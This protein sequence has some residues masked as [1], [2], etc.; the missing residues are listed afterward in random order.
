MV[1]E[2]ISKIL[3]LLQ[4]IREQFS[5]AESEERERTRVFSLVNKLTEPI[6]ILNE[7][8]EEAAQKKED[9][10]ATQNALI[11]YYQF[12]SSQVKNEN[13]INPFLR[14]K[15][16]REIFETL[17]SK[18]N[19][20]ITRLSSSIGI[21][22]IEFDISQVIEPQDPN[23]SSQVMNMGMMMMNLENS[24][25]NWQSPSHTFYISNQENLIPDLARID[26]NAESYTFDILRE[27]FGLDKQSAKIL[28]DT[29]DIERKGS[30]TPQEFKERRKII[31]KGSVPDKASF[32]F[33]SWDLDKNGFLDID[34]V[35][36]ALE[37]AY[38]LITKFYFI[39]KFGN[40]DK[41]MKSLNGLE[42]KRFKKEFKSKVKEM[43]KKNEVEKYIN[44]MFDQAV[45]NEDDELSLE[46]FVKYCEQPN[47]IVFTF[48]NALS[49]TMN[50]FIHEKDIP[51][52]VLDEMKKEKQRMNK[53]QNKQEKAKLIQ[54]EVQVI[55]VTTPIKLVK[56]FSYPNVLLLASDDREEYLNDVENSIKSNGTCF[57]TTI[58]GKVFIPSFDDLLNFNIIFLYADYN[59]LDNKQLSENLKLYVESGGKLII[60]SAFALATDFPN[61]DLVGS[62]LDYIPL[63]KG[64][65][66]RNEPVKI[67]LKFG[68]KILEGVNSFDGG[69]KSFRI[70]TN[71]VN[72]GQI[73]VKWDDGTPLVTQKTVLG[74]GGKNGNVIVLNMF[75]C[76]T[77]AIPTGWDRKTNGHRLI[78]N[79]IYHSFYSPNSI[80]I[81]PPPRPIP[82]IL[83]VASDDRDAFLNDVKSSIKI[84]GNC[85]VK[86]FNGRIST[87]KLKKL[88]KYDVVF[89]YADY[90]WLDNLTL[91]NNLQAFVESGGRL[92]M[93]SAFALSNQHP[94]K[95]I[96]G[97]FL[98]LVPFSKGIVSR[99]GPV[100]LD[101]TNSPILEG[102]NYFDGGTASFRIKT[103]DINGGQV[104]AL[105]SDG[106]PLIVQKQIRGYQG[107]DG[108]IMVLN[109][110]PC[111]TDALQVGWNPETDGRKL[112]SNVVQYAFQYQPIILPKEMMFSGL[113]VLIVASDDRDSYLN[114]VKASIQANGN[115]YIKTFNGR[116]STPSIED[117]VIYDVVFLYSDFNWADNKTLSNNLQA[118]VQS[119]GRLVMCSA[120]NLSTQHPQKDLVGSFLSLVPFSKG[121]ISRSGPFYL[122]KNNNHPILEGVN[123]FDGGTASFRIQSTNIKKGAEIL[124][125]WNDGYPL[126]VQ[127]QIRGYQGKDGLIVLLNMFPCS[128]NALQVGWN[129][130]TDGR[131]LISNVV[132]YA[133]EYQP[134]ILPEE[135]GFSAANVLVVA[136]DDRDSYL[137]DVKSSIQTNGD[138]NITTFNGKSSTPTIQDLMGYDVVFLY[139]DFN[140]ADNTTLSNNLKT[141]VQSGGKLVMSSAFNLSSQ[142]PKKDLVGDFVSL[143]PLSKGVVSRDG[144]V[145]LDKRNSHEILEGINSFDG[146]KASFR[147][148]TNEVNGGE[149]LAKWTD[150]YPLIT[151]KVI[152][153]YQG[154]NGLIVLLNMFPISS[155]AI[156]TGWNIQTDGGRLISNIIKYALFN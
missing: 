46:E 74:K 37:N 140:W 150:G 38:I 79:T 141:F 149:I 72:G 62:I 7:S 99:D 78:A 10:E 66:S 105:W 124:A 4:A 133:F 80:Y 28:F 54:E 143:V 126:I 61:K 119:G 73:L 134:V 113:N 91:S 84:N 86:T 19:D 151:K 122:D 42:K 77:N 137:N 12:L 20:C 5:I 135:I 26:S 53:K 75:P 69:D 82:N 125:K 22:P 55:E 63:S 112:I 128:N 51:K 40:L 64:V 101:K 43:M 21:E 100:Y 116:I 106:N 130:Q 88:M 23:L 131:K 103:N 95:D 8:P 31:E 92:V 27:K 11:D 93:C 94:N 117:L 87:P 6:Q 127:K 39:R 18:L 3:Q 85:Y 138:C 121:I 68:H 96:V 67:D 111:S 132:K 81:L 32:V 154:K 70:K 35:K 17:E 41:Y 48:L 71:N 115:C 114:D 142:H 1:T 146:G 56:E 148:K 110:F 123:Y 144:P 29:F 104:L 145:Y 129:S 9:L 36:Y 2:I 156:S 59:W 13:K 24:N 102:V 58:N 108:L 118:F 139:S 107:K 15:E 98:S 153:S 109:M 57:V 44:Y 89:L 45:K 50:I 16:T 120:F 90:N 136:S 152:K 97:S 47:N 34:E 60:C 33:K 147:I 83:I 49:E 155:N 65:V 76:S 52:E 25:Q 30:I 14:T